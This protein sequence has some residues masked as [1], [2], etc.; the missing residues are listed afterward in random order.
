MI[1]REY[2]GSD[3]ASTTRRSHAE[4]Q[5]STMPGD[6]V[7]TLLDYV[8][9]SDKDASIVNEERRSVEASNQRAVRSDFESAYKHHVGLKVRRGG[10]RQWRIPPLQPN[11]FLT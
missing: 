11:G 3:V 4:P 6:R 1:E 10:V 7:G 9:C 8:A 5:E 2:L